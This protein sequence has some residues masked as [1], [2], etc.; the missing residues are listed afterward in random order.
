MTTKVIETLMNEHRVIERVLGSLEAFAA[1]LD[2][3]T[4]DQRRTVADYAEFFREFADRC[5]HGKEEDG[6]FTALTE[7]G[8]PADGGPVA[9]MLHEHEAG[10]NHVRALAEI[11]AGDGP[12]GPDER[13][14]VSR[15]AAEYVPLLRQHITKEDAILFPAAERALPPAVL[16]AL[17]DDFARHERDEMGRGTHE[18]LHRLADDLIAGCPP[19]APA[20][21][22]PAMTSG[23]PCGH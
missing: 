8:F 21:P 10:R 11:G 18:R 19:L 1:G 2:E 22:Q 6:L 14:R 17:A 7:H 9:V 23:S 16:E 15:H 20:G 3:E 13:A 5:H 4:A 12:L